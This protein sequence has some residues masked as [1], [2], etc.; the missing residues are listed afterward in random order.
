MFF[1][2]RKGNV[3]I[4]AADVATGEIRQLTDNPSV[5]E[6]PFYSPDGLHI[7][8]TEGM[9]RLVEER[10][11][12]TFIVATEV[13][14]LHRMKRVAPTKKL[15]AADPEAVCAFMKTITLSSVRDALLHEQYPVTVPG[16]IAARARAALA[17]MI[18]IGC[19]RS[20]ARGATRLSAKP[21]D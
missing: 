7:A 15:V 3:D 11:A 14:I 18:A 6:D 20:E 4:W 19:P 17:R 1:S 8:S 16:E 9:I 2:S 12:T 13:V 10:P 21:R 5:D